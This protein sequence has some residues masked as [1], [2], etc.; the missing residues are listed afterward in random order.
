[1]MLH[2]VVAPVLLDFFPVFSLE[3]ASGHA[4][5]RHVARTAGDS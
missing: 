5:E 1:M 4:G 2:E 3:E